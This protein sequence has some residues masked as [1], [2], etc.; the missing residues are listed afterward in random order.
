MAINADIT[1]EADGYFGC[2]ESWG[3]EIR[4]WVVRAGHEAEAL[5]VELIIDGERVATA[6]CVH[7][8]LD[9]TAI[10]GRS[11][12]AGFVLPASSIKLPAALKRK[13]SAA[14]VEIEFR[15]K[16][17]G[18]QVPTLFERPISV[19]ELIEVV[20]A[21]S[22]R[23]LSLGEIAVASKPFVEEVV[24]KDSEEAGVKLIAFY[25]PQFHP[26]P[27]NDAWWG[28][29]F[30]EWTNVSQA[31]PQYPGHYQ[32][33]VPG[34]L[35]FYDLRLPEV[36]EAQADLARQ[37]G[38]HGFCYYYYWFNGRRILERPLQ[39]MLDSG[40]PDFPFCI[41][42]ANET[43]SR[44][45]DGSEHE[46]LLKQEHTPESD[47][48][49]IHDVIPILKDPRYIRINGAPVLM[50]Y[51]ASLFPDLRST[52]DVWRR[53]CAENGIPNIHLTIVESFG[54]NEPYSIGFDSS[55]QF[56]PHGIV[57]G[58]IREEMDGVP[59]EF[60]GKI[61]D[62]EEVVE[63]ELSAP[64]A[65]H[66]RFNG[67]MV[68]WDNTARRKNKSH[69][70]A[71][72][73]PE[74][75]E[76]WLRNAVERARDSHPSGERLVFINAWN[77]WAEGAHLEPDV[78]HGRAY[79]E[80]TLRAHAG[81]SSPSVL[82]DYARKIGRLEGDQLAS[83]IADM[84]ASIESAAARQRHAERLLAR[85]HALGE[86]GTMMSPAQPYVLN[87]L[88]MAPL[89]QFF[90]ERINGLPPG[91]SHAALRKDQYLFVE[92]W[93]MHPEAPTDSKTISHLVL[94]CTASKQR[95]YAPVFGRRQRPDVAQAF[96]TQS[97][98]MT[99]FSGVR[100]FVD[101]SSV[102]PGE[103]RMGLLQTSPSTTSLNFV[104]G[105]VRVA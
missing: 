77:E 76:V 25:L 86:S 58:D 99:L 17:L 35:G 18:H 3:S 70:F 46:V 5:A 67:V 96:R 42:W 90:V 39:E 52:A 61:Y 84:Q 49:F 31:Q 87:A 27:E 10:T 1:P 7:P 64:A 41:C 71:K 50:V 89:G 8:R 75:Y 72:S 43:W 63:S 36:R 95:Y 73:T 101:L 57:A 59:E 33:H 11:N 26:V 85:D 103:Y 28:P 94:E 4:G 20:G 69:M 104:E 74:L 102:A 98:E 51:R 80:A 83:W 34:E 62:F 48:A 40:K 45:W 56:P 100:A 55:V 60:T 78:R 82:L 2:I 79:L 21:P 91:I 54:F 92:G 14:Q 38:I 19:E 32:P 15:I 105:A 24:S 30:T 68:S 29:G 12:N 9:I 16:A 81:Q 22:A 23:S 47:I 65:K 37:Y 93:A 66:K 44:R 97:E 13:A 88:P 6:Y 53:I